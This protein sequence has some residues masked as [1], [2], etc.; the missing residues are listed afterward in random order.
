MT[1]VF[2]GTSALQSAETA[3]ERAVKS[4]SLVRFQ[5]T[6]KE[7]RSLCSRLKAVKNDAYDPCLKLA[8][9]VA[10]VTGC[11]INESYFV[12]E[13]SFAPVHLARNL[14]FG[15]LLTAGYVFASDTLFSTKL[16]PSFSDKRSSRLLACEHPLFLISKAFSTNLQSVEDVEAWTTDMRII[17]E[18]TRDKTNFETGIDTIFIFS[19]ELAQALTVIKKHKDLGALESDTQKWVA[20][21]ALLENGI[22][23]SFKK[24]VQG[25]Y[26]EETETVT[27]TSVERILA[28]VKHEL[29]NMNE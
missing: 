19:R 16:L 8:A 14:F 1:F 24:T 29:L 28:G 5:K 13:E 4:H 11:Y 26:N 3:I 12:Y 27:V 21:L 23:A 7:L 25:T 6:H 10:F 15:G 2:F 22:K 20:K 18:Y 9:C 17:A